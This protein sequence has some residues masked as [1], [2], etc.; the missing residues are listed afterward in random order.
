VVQ[1]DN[2]GVQGVFDS[3]FK[4][5]ARLK[6]LTLDDWRTHKIVCWRNKTADAHTNTI[7][8]AL[9]FTNR[10]EIGESL[11]LAA[12]LQID[13]KILGYTDEELTVTAIEEKVHSFVEGTVSSFSLAVK[14]K[15]YLLQI[16][17]NAD[18][19]QALLNIRAAKASKLTGKARKEAWSSFWEL[20]NKFHSVRY[21]YALTSHRVQGSTYT[22]VTVDVADIL[23]NPNKREAF[24]A[25]YVACTRPT[26]AL[27]TV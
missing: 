8:E 1:A 17:K 20:K 4:E 25:L 6:K 27:H 10:F 7:R 2:D 23:A 18:K 13:G 24:R 5:R 14:E 11:L 3:P 9:G 26:T 12:P 21:G 22:S 15:D 19:F 16:P